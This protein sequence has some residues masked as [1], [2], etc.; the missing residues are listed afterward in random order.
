MWDYVMCHEEV[1]LVPYGFGI[2]QSHPPFT[3]FPEWTSHTP[4]VCV[5]F[6]A[7]VWFEEEEKEEEEP[8]NG[9]FVHLEPTPPLSDVFD[10]VQIEPEQRRNFTREK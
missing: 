8:K 7:C 6:R 4:G 3:P 5:C 10:Q 2:V 1:C 9:I